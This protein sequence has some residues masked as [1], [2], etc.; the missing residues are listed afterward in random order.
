MFKRKTL[1][2][3]VIEL[4]RENRFLRELNANAIQRIVGVL[5]L[6]DEKAAD[7]ADLFEPWAPD[8]SYSPGKRIRCGEN[9]D[10]SAVLYEVKKEHTSE[11]CSPP[12]KKAGLYKKIRRG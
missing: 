1:D 4:E 6:S 2:D 5:D 8:R 3:R 7:F 12:G 10:G 9:A 11:D